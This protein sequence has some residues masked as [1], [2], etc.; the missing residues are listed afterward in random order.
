[1][2]SRKAGLLLGCFLAFFLLFPASLWAQKIC[3][4]P[5]H[6]GSDPGAVGCGLR[7]ATIN[8]DVSTRLRELLT[9]AGYTVIMTR[10]TDVYLTLTARANYANSNGANRFVSIHTNAFNGSAT[11]IETFCSPNGSTTSF[12]QRNKIQE[13]M[14]AAWKLTNRGG[15]TANFTVLTA[16]N[17]PATLSELA[18]IDNCA[19]DAVLLAS[20]TRRQEAAVAHLRALQRSLGHSTTPT[21]GTARGV[22]YEDRGQGTADMTVRLAGAKV[23]AN[24]GGASVTASSPDAAWSFSLAPATYTISAQHT[25]YRTGSVSC[26]VKANDVTWCSIGLIK[27]TVTEPPPEPVDTAEPVV[28]VA[29]VVEVVEEAEDVTPGDFLEPVTPLEGEDV[30]PMDYIEEALD[31]DPAVDVMENDPVVPTDGHDDVTAATE[32]GQGMVPRTTESACGCQVQR[33]SAPLPWWVLVAFLGLVALWWRRS[34]VRRAG[35]GALVALTALC[36]LAWHQEGLADEVCVFEMDGPSLVETR[37]LTTGAQAAVLSPDGTQVL[38]ASPGFA[39][40]S[41]GQV[42][43]ALAARSVSTDPRAGYLPLWVDGQVATRLPSE[44]FGAEP[45]MLF[46]VQGEFLGPYVPKDG[47]WVFQQDDAIFL[48]Q[49]DGQVAQLTGDDD[50]YFAPL[51]APDRRFVAYN[52]LEGGL[53]VQRLEDGARFSFGDGAHLRFD[54]SGRF[55]VFDRVSDDGEHL[56]GSELYLLD[57]QGQTPRLYRLTATPER[58][59]LYPSLDATGTMLSFTTPEL[60]VYVGRI[61]WP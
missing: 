7:E 52:G 60:D 49:A 37:L 13:E 27:E 1:M 32:E 57:L 36:W 16:T 23:T 4:D 31:R 21:N 35:V 55:A 39:E 29:E 38:L 40:L 43:G 20:P 34:G 54:G 33:Q 24:P 41:A 10:T 22:V 28:E 15:K 19:I 25:G 2:Y 8:L 50:R 47:L 51:L 9:T 48:R 61:Q 18:F 45:M 56:T 26:V 3:I 12:D 46:S 44:P 17:M 5:G 30:Q 58:I 14:V 53:F 11:G 59:E 6:G 42:D